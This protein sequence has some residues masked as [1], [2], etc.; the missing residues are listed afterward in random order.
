M[1]EIFPGLHRFTVT[2]P[3]LGFTI[4]HYLLASEPAVLFATGTMDEA[5]SSLPEIESILNGRKMG[6]IFV[7]HFES[8]ECGGLPV[9]LERF[10]EAKVVCSKLAAREL[11]GYGIHADIIPADGTTVIEDG[12]IRLRFVDYPSEVHLQD[13][14]LCYEENSGVV[15]SSDVMLRGFGQG[16]DAEDSVWEELVDAVGTDRV[17]D[18]AR[19]QR[20]KDSLKTWN[21]RLDATGHGPCHRF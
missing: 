19:L 6:Y 10:P 20:M 13:G 2:V 18:P 3:S 21:P 14:L 12:D 8:D 7:S 16:P 17:P 1:S 11:L 15:Y 5:K 9:F 4:H